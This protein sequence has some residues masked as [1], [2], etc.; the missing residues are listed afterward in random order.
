[1]KI[2]FA[3]TFK[4]GYIEFTPTIALSYYSKPFCLY[5]GWIIWVIIIEFNH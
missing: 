4:K 2:Q 1:M 3:T 5:F